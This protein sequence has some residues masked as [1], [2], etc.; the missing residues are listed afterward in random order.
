MFCNIKLRQHISPIDQNNL[1]NS[2]FNHL[3]QQHSLHYYL[4]MFE[5]HFQIPQTTTPYEAY[6][7]PPQFLKIGNNNR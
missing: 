1:G 7:T 4:S 5:K 2:I 3:W 6:T